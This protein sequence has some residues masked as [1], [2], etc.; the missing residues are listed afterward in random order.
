MDLCLLL[1]HCYRWL[2]PPSVL[3]PVPPSVLVPVPPP[4]PTVLPLLVPPVEPLL[5]VPVCL[6]VFVFLL[7]VL[8]LVAVLFFFTADVEAV[9]LPDVTSAIAVTITKIAISVVIVC[10]PAS[11][12]SMRGLVIP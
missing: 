3:V 8:F 4:T 12:C 5:P 2:E 11:I 9:M 6:S 1:Y 7:P 10:I